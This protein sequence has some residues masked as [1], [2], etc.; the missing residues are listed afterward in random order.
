MILYLK[1]NPLSLLSLLRYFT[2]ISHKGDR[3]SQITLAELTW[4]INFEMRNN[5]RPEGV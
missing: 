4:Q 5:L 1:L 3:K 2:T